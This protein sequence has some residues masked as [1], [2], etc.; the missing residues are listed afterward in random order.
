MLDK[1]SFVNAIIAE[2]GQISQVRDPAFVGGHGA[3][4]TV[5]LPSKWKVRVETVSGWDD[6]KFVLFNLDGGVSRYEHEIS[7]SQ[8]YEELTGHKLNIWRRLRQEHSS[9]E[10][11][12]FTFPKGRIGSIYF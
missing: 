2:Y 5:T 4:L 11:L 3:G 9:K 6:F 1:V 10:C 12:Q 8:F 7:L